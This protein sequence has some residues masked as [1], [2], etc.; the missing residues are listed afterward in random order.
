MGPSLVF[1]MHDAVRFANDVFFPHEYSGIINVRSAASTEL[2][3]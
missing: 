1:E 2:I 3:D